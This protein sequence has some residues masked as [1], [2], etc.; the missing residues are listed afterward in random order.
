MKVDCRAKSARSAEHFSIF[1]K[2]RGFL[3]LGEIFRGGRDPFQGGGRFYFQPGHFLR[4]GE[5]PEFCIRFQFQQNALLSINS[6]FFKQLCIPLASFGQFLPALGSCWIDLGDFAC[7]SLCQ[8]MTPNGSSWKLMAAHGSSW[9]L[10]A[11]HGSRQLMA[12]NVSLCQ[13][14]SSRFQTESIFSLV[15]V[16]LLVLVKIF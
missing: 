7:V 1:C 16:S 9:Q 10:M 4:G 15:S 13:L 5:N 3:R 6:Q 8:L 2:K 12:A 14:F 11:A